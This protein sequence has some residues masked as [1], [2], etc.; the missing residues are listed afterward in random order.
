MISRETPR[1]ASCSTTGS[2]VSSFSAS[3]PRRGLVNLLVPPRVPR[4]GPRGSVVFSLVPRVGLVESV[5]GLVE[6][7]V[8]LVFA[9]WSLVLASCLPR[10]ASWSLVESVVGPRFPRET[11]RGASYSLVNASYSLVF[12][13]WNLVFATQG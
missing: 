2:D 10:G 5:V 13:S 1:E 9:S 4:R 11:R 8:G 3:R 12:A 6:S 7:V